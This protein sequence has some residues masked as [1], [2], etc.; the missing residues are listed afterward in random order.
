MVEIIA[1]GDRDPSFLTHREIDAALAL[2]PGCA[3]VATDSEQARDLAS[4]DGIWLLPGTP[5][6]DDQVAFDAIA[7][8]LATSNAVPRHLRRLSVRLR[9]A[10]SRAR[11][12]HRGR[13]RRERSG[14]R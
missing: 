13:P 9:R 2:L 12:C 1:L 11:R 4:A 6:R 3:W 14:G 8:C 7:H 5:S 10:R